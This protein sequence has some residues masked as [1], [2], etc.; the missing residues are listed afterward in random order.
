MTL[1]RRYLVT[2]RFA[3]MD[4]VGAPVIGIH[5]QRPQL[6]VQR[7]RHTCALAPRGAT[8]APPAVGPALTPL[9]LH[10]AVTD[11]ADAV[12]ANTD[13]ATGRP[14][15]TEHA[16]S[17]TNISKLPIRATGMSLRQPS[18]F[19]PSEGSVASAE[20]SATSAS[21]SGFSSAGADRSSVPTTVAAGVAA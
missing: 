17:S 12:P 20:S 16:A 19:S 9:L 2:S 8:L 11:D 15:R 6:P 13:Q 5:P 3:G 14:T 4:A 1:G 21:P 10:T 7:A 18:D